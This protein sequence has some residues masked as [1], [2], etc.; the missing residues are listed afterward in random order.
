MNWAGGVLYKA[1]CFPYAVFIER[2]HQA[3]FFYERLWNLELLTVML[4]ISRKAYRLGSLV[5]LY[6]GGY[7]L[8]RFLIKGLWADSLYLLSGLRMSQLLSPILVLAGLILWVM[9][10][11]SLPQKMCSA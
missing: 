7:G 4:I 9:K 2:L 8:G 1:L 10:I 5:C 6:F 11:R 3:M